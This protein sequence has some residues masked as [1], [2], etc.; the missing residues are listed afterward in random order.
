M[1]SEAFIWRR[2]VSAAGRRSR[3]PH[4]QPPACK[5]ASAMIVMLLAWAFPAT[6]EE[7]DAQIV[8][9]SQL[10]FNVIL[11]FVMLKILLWFFLLG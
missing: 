1:S 3:G 6:L 11:Q 5:M 9:L 4:A 7:V 2:R 10:D 8:S